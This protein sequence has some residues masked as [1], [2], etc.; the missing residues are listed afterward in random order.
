[1][2]KNKLFWTMLALCAANFAAQLCVYPTL[3]ETVR[4]HRLTE[5]PLSDR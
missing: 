4:G 2:K 1:M 3:P 5:I